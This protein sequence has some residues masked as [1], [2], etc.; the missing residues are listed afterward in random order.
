MLTTHSPTPLQDGKSAW[1]MLAPNRQTV[2]KA[3]PS[4]TPV[5]QQQGTLK[6][7]VGLE[8]GPVALGQP[9][10]ALEGSLPKNHRLGGF[11][12][13]RVAKTHKEKQPF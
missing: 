1:C 10:R 6:K 13:S 9:E 8:P 12:R 2:P 11:L 5:G 3:A 7:W 4:G